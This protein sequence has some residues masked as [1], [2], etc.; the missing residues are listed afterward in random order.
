MGLKTYHRLLK[1]IKILI[2]INVF[3][4]PFTMGCSGDSGSQDGASATASVSGGDAADPLK[5]LQDE[6]RL[7]TMEMGGAPALPSGSTVLN[8]SGPEV[9]SLFPPGADPDHD[10]VPNVPITGHPEIKV[11]NCPTVA[12]P[13]QEDANHNGIGDACE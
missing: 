8:G 10:N 3:L 7:P 9:T 1:M 6:G 4:L 11:D 5:Q 13:G 2:L 12:N